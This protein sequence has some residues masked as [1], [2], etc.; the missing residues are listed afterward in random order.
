V[1]PSQRTTLYADTEPYMTPPAQSFNSQPSNHRHEP[2][3]GG[4]STRGRGRGRGRSQGPPDQPKKFFCHFHGAESDHTTNRCPEKKKTLDRMEVEKKAKLVS[5]TSWPGS[6]QTYN[7]QE[8]QH[9]NLIP[10]SHAYN[11]TPQAL[12]SAPPFN[13]FQPSPAFSYN[14][15]PANWQP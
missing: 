5:H 7:P 6:S 4:R 10:S 1:E 15:Y 12:P 9:Y 3:R 2:N 8:T 14:P 13:P 11:P